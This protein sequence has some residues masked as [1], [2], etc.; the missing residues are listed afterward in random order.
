MWNYKQKHSKQQ[1]ALSLR[2]DQR[3]CG[4]WFTSLEQAARHGTGR[5]SMATKKIAATGN[6]GAEN[7]ELENKGL[8][9]V[10]A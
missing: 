8:G 10:T 5:I 2:I 4:R 1:N 6:A 3:L 7:A 9:W